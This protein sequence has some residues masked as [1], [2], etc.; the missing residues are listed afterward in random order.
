[1][2]SALEAQSYNHRNTREVPPFYFNN[3]AFKLIASHNEK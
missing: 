1:M 3:S 2:P